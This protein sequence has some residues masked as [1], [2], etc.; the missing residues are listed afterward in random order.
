[1]KVRQSEHTLYSHIL[2][3]RVKVK[4]KD[5]LKKN[6]NRLIAKSSHIANLHSK[7]TGWN[8]VEK[9]LGKLGIKL[10]DNKDTFKDFGIVLDEIGSK[11]NGFTKVEQNAISVA[12]SG[13]RNRENFLVLMNN[14]GKA[15]EYAGVSA[16]SSGTAM[17]K[18][19]AYQ[20]SIEAKSK[21]FTATL[22]GLSSAFVDSDLVK[23]ILDIGSTGLSGLTKLID[24]FGTIPTVVGAATL[25][26]GLFNKNIGII[27]YAR[28][29]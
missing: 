10:R 24:K 28:V 15:L 14:Y 13:V 25:A 9:V 7:V 5:T 2:R 16:N 11:W 12:I 23:G 29:A 22:E 18:F 4:C 8:D 20:D 19:E 6:L 1:M 17:K 3:G 26:L 27:K 21:K